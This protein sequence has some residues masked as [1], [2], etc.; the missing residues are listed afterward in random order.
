MNDQIQ[1]F[2][3]TTLLDGLLCLPEG[4]QM[5]FRRMYSHNDMA[6]PL[7][8]IVQRMP[9]EKLDWAMQQVQRSINKLTTAAV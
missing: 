6:A 3:R 4:Y 9:V 7:A 8:S 5:T 1:Q 2:A